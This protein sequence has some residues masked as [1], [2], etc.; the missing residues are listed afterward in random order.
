MPLFPNAAAIAALPDRFS[1]AGPPPIRATRK[2][3]EWGSAIYRAYAYLAG[4]VRE[5]SHHAE[6][7][8]LLERTIADGPD[9]AKVRRK[10]DF[11]PVPVVTYSKEA[12]AEIMRQAREIERET[13]AARAKGAHGG[14]LGRM[15]LQ[16]LEWFAFTLWP[17]SGRFGMVPSLAH[18]TTGARMSR[19]TVVEAMKRLETFGFLG[20]Q[21]RRKRVTTPLGVKIVQASN[22]YSL[23][24]ARGL[25]AL[26]VAVFRKKPPTT[27]DTPSGFSEST[28]S[29][30]I[31]EH[32]ESLKPQRQDWFPKPDYEPLLT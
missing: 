23:S 12:A 20:V 26:A 6:L 1:V 28:K 31:R 4:R 15:G 32:P 22:A 27:G 11:K 24:L 3:V 17:K 30:A 21:P 29:P 10:A 16:L 13:Y 8:S 14:G 5:P 25:G 19:A 2:A 9:F 7:Y 18:I